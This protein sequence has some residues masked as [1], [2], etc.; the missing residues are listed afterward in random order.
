MLKV[1]ER[2]EVGGKIGERLVETLELATGDADGVGRVTVTVKEGGNYILRAEGTD[3][4]E[5]PVSGRADV[6]ISGDDD[7]I[8]LR[9]LADRHTYKAGDRADIP[10]HWRGAPA[11]ALVTFQGAKI[12]DY[13]LVELKTGRN[14]L[15]VDFDADLAPNFELA[16]ALMTDG[17]RKGGREDRGETLPRSQLAVHRRARADG[18]N[19]VEIGWR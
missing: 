7:E 16:V 11:L 18:Q 8:R 4:F 3:R 14:N 13:R 5:N 19:E 17:D 9:I 6:T 12:L 10:L 2:T 1:L 15:P